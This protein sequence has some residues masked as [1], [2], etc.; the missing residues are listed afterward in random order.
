MSREILL[1]DDHEVVRKGIKHLVESYSDWHICG[2]AGNGKE[3]VD[4]VLALQPDLVLMDI[5]MPIMNGFEALREI[6][7]F[8]PA[9]KTIILSMHDS[10]Q[11]RETAEQAGAS[12][13]VV[14][15]RSVEDLR[16]T[17]VEV[18][19]QAGSRG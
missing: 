6:R 4:K 19:H 18:L 11:I 2:E 7:K 3:A 16:R 12:T 14:K 8:S 5:S 17:I 10:P 13:Y 1:V 9:T 15:S